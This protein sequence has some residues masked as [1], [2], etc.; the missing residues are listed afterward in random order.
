VKYIVVWKPEYTDKVTVSFVKYGEGMLI[1]DIM[2]LAHE[3]E[4]L[5]F[6]EYELYIII[7]ATDPEV[8]W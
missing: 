7:K 2:V 6:G 4:G 8:V 3:Y 1:G 5:E